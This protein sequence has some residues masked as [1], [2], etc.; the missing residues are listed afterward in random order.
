MPH[1]RSPRA[2]NLRQLSELLALRR[3][4]LDQL[5]GFRNACA[6][7]APKSTLVLRPAIASCERRMLD[8]IAAGAHLSRRADIVASPCRLT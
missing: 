1:R 3:R 5:G 2:E 4:I 8:F 7:L 6:E